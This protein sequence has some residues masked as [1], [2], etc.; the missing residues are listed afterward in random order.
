VREIR[1]KFVLN[2]AGAFRFEPG[3]DQL[4][5]KVLSL[6]KIAENE[7]NT[8]QMAT[9]LSNGSSTVVD[10]NFSSVSANQEGMIGQAYDDPQAQHFVNRV[11]CG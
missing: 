4:F 8:K 3:S 9:V 6:G 7:D 1:Q 11:F 5:L 2:C 10:G